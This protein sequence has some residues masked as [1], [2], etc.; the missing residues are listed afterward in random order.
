VR[1]ATG[2]FKLALLTIA[3]FLLVATVI[4]LVMRVTASEDEAESLATGDA[5]PRA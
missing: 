5:A 2:N 3:A 1:S 4:A